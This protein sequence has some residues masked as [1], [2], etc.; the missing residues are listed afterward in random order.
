MFYIPFNISL[1]IS[2]TSHFKKMKVV[3]ILENMDGLI[4]TGNNS[5]LSVRK[6]QYRVPYFLLSMWNST[7]SM[8]WNFW[9]IP[10]SKAN[11]WIRCKA[12]FRWPNRKAGNIWLMKSYKNITFSY[13][14]PRF[15]VIYTFSYPCSRKVT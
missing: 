2:A 11:Y 6:D 15:P 7:S 9:K 14:F 5:N 8:W 13:V 3:F 4:F 1:A 10:S 12:D